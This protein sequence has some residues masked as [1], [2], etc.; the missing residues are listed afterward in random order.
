MRCWSTWINIICLQCTKIRTGILAPKSATASHLLVAI[1]LPMCKFQISSSLVHKKNRNFSHHLYQVLPTFS[2]K[3]FQLRSQKN[4]KT[5]NTFFYIL[6]IYLKKKKRPPKTKINS[7]KISQT[8]LFY[9]FPL[10]PT[11]SPLANLP[12]PIFYLLLGKNKR[13]E[14]KNEALV[15]MILPVTWVIFRWTSRCPPWN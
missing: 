7:P 9:H 6:K 13:L 2:T 15:Q 5:I 8:F 11:T 4:N 1:T 14:P 12:F 3:F 10:F